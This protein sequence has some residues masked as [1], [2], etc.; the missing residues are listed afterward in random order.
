MPNPKKP[1]TISQPPGAY[2]FRPAGVS[3]RNAG[4]VILSIDEYEAMRLIDYDEVDQS[5]AAE[6]LGVSRPTCM[7][8]VARARRKVAEALSGGKTI[9]IEGGPVSFRAN[10]YRCGTCGHLWSEEEP[11]EIENVRCP[12]CE[13]SRII[14]LAAMGGWR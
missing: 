10:R 8:M 11:D 4:R 7:R 2:E 6:Q 9:V 12:R 13:G 14:D 5:V 3:Q 1:R